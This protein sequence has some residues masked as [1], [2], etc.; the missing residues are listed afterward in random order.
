MQVKEEPAA[1][2]PVTERLE[3]GSVSVPNVQGQVGREAVA[4]LLSTSLEPRT[5]GSGRVMAQSPAPGAHVAA[6]GES[7]A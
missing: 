1:A 2:Q 6:R 7:D 5:C 3:Q 4:R